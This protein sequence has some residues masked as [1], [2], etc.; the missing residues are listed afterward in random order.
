MLHR[1]LV[2]KTKYKTEV[3]SCQESAL[4]TPQTKAH[5]LQLAAGSGTSTKTRVQRKAK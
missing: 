2:L 4:S 1:R 3:A 5:V